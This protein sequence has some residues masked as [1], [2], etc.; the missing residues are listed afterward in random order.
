MGLRMGAYATVWQVEPVSETLTK[1]RIS[2]S[3]KNKASG[4][5]EQDFSGYVSF[6]GTLAAKKAA[7]LQERDRIKI[8]DVDVTNRFDKEKNITYT[9][10]KIFSFEMADDALRNPPPPSQNRQEHF[11]V[12]DGVVDDD[13][14][15]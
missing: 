11:N 10:F 14:P 5:Y 1:G 8:G 9:N 15:F 4:E 13:I 2:I 12:D 7:S 3:R 6:V